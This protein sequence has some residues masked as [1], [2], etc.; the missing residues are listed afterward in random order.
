[1]IGV[2]KHK[3]NKKVSNDRLVNI[4]NK[5]VSKSRV[6]MESKKRRFRAKD[7]SKIQQREYAVVSDRYRTERAKK[8][9]Y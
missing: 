9:H 3:N 8:K 4:F 2:Q 6:L 5:V 7:K 1:M